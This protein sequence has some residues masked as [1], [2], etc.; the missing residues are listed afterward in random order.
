M[1]PG[2][3]RWLMGCSGRLGVVVFLE[4]RK[5]L[6][7]DVVPLGLLGDEL[8]NEALVV[9]GSGKYHAG[10]QCAA[11]GWEPIRGIGR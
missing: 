10:P 6:T 3:A 7:W 5:I 9:G 11:W 2:F 1:N 8:H 4:A